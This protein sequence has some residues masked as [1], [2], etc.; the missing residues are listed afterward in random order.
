MNSNT[1]L[2]PL[3]FNI[4][5]LCANFDTFTDNNKN[6]YTTEGYEAF[7]NDRYDDRMQR[8]EVYLYILQIF[9]NSK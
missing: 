9:T 2:L 8:M 6:L 3:C 5:S 4:R 7:H 1:D